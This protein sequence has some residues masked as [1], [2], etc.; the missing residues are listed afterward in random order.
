MA[1]VVITGGAGFIG[2]NL[3]Y[4]LTKKGHEVTVI[5]NFSYG[6]EE[7]LIREGKKFCEIVKKDIRDADLLEYFKGKNIVFHM[8]AISNLPTCQSK[9]GEA[10][11]VNVGGTTNVL[12]CARLANIKK[13][14]FA[15]TN[16]LYENNFEP[17]F[18]E[19]M[20]VDPFLAYSLSKYLSEQVCR[21]FR[22]AYGMNIV[23]TRY[24]N[25]YGPN[26]DSKRK[27]PALTA[28]IIRELLNN[29]VPS[30][31]SDGNQRRDYTFIDEVNE[32]NLLCMERE[33]ANGET[34]NVASGNTYSVNEIYEKIAKHLNS[35][36]LPVFNKANKLWDDY[37][38]LFEG[39]YPLNRDILEKE[40]V[41]TTLG[42]TKKAKLIL[43]WKAKIP[44]EDGLKKMID[45]I[46]KSEQP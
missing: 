38:V 6:Y 3:A 28:Y 1:K 33:E 2:S 4:F 9:P 15:G 42:D 23:I 39:R 37:S 26:Q 46:T 14:I 34:F 25:V 16:A 19:D 22:R 30:L 40:V 32:M 18:R 27:S 17:P 35:K 11:S 41:K 45:F 31:Y 29:R 8:A 36:I 7:N 44:M 12:E 20:P 10:M 43:G 24:H 5:D 13:V 21:S